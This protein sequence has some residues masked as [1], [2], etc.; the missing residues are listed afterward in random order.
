MGS[1]GENDIEEGRLLPPETPWVG[2]FDFLKRSGY[3]LR[4]RYR[5]DWVAP[6][7]LKPGLYSSDF[8]EGI[9]CSRPSL[10]DAQRLSDGKTVFLKHTRKDSPEIAI[11]EYFSSEP[12]RSDPRNH[13][14]PVLEVLKNE[15]DPDHVILVLP[16]LR[17]LDAPE[18]ASVRECVD[19][20]QQTLEGLVFMHEHKVAHR[21]CAWGN[22]MMDGR[23]LYPNGWHP[24]QW[25]FYPNGKVMRGVD[26]SRTAVGGVR[27]Y[28]IDFGISTKDQ[29]E[30]LGIH[31]QELSPELSDTV[32]YNPY[33][34]D[35]Y[36]LGMA[37]QHFLIERHSGLDFLL[38][39][40]E[41][42]TPQKPSERPSAAEALQRWSTIAQG[43][44]SLTLSKRL[45]SSKEEPESGLSRTLKDTSY[46]IRDLWWT[47][48][49][50]KKPPRPFL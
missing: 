47:A 35:V 36:I 11:G 37:Y 6:W 3:L 30:V 45:Y 20:V 28:F 42:M 41:Y 44:S 32:P 5:P 27:Y 10:M 23:R 19:F 16:W 49:V 9:V 31:G 46:R 14:L 2:R 40:I 50:S 34:L 25:S 12:L 21:D 22:V 17:R 24:Q 13:C 29:D 18:P 1:E 8:E 38:P 7:K 4:P 39:L 26:P 15:D 43:L 33:K 48:T